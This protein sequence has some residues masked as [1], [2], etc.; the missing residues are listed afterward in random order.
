MGVG[1]FFFLAA[2]VFL[3]GM[4]QESMERMGR[5]REIAGASERE[6]ENQ[7]RGDGS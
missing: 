2:A 7:E 6:K 5:K 3:L 4:I 1:V